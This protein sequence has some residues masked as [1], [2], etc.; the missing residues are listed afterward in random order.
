MR[1]KILS[2]SSEDESH[3]MQNFSALKK[4]YRLSVCLCDYA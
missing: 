4:S 3:L 2:T 1:K